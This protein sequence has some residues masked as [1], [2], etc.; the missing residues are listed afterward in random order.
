MK[1]ATFNANSIRSRDKIISDWIRAEQ[2]DILCLQETKVQDKDFPVKG[3]T[4]LGYKVIFRGQK[5]YNG[6]A[7]ASR[8]PFSDV[9]LNL[10]DTEEGQ[11]RFVSAII[12][13][14]NVINAYVPQGFAPGTDKF[15]YKLEWLQDLLAHIDR[16]YNNAMPVIMTGDF[17]V[18]LEPI[19]LYDPEGMKGEVGFHPDEQDMIR[20]FMDWGFIDIFRVHHK[21]GGQYTFWDYRIPN[22]FKRN[23]G[24][25]I[26][27]IF[28][29]KPLADKL[30]RVWIDKEPRAREKPSDH[31]FLVAEFDVGQ[32]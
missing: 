17:N 15:R 32:F 6:V 2:P 30:T 29:T 11:A 24:W 13:D 27:Y 18:A 12:D 7:I 10:K 1:I 9:R 16:N 8:H 21:E 31:T 26:D 22:G 25:R 3:F 14:V 23:M 19:D 5:A 28:A 20:R 4:D